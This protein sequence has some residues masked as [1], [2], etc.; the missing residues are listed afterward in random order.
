MTV[1]IFSTYEQA[2]K[3]YDFNF[4]K[5]RLLFRSKLILFNEV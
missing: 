4:S 1:L 5:H 3:I 2:S